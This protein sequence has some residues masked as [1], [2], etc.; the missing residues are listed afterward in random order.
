MCGCCIFFYLF[1]LPLLLSR[2]PATTTAAA[3]Q[4]Y[5]TDSPVT[6]LNFLSFRLCML[7]TPI[8]TLCVSF[9]IPHHPLV[10]LLCY[11]EYSVEEHPRLHQHLH[12]REDVGR[13]EV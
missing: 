10:S 13:E 1:F 9:L 3:V 12:R 2:S 4:S 8:Y 5:T 7:R 11:I 6:Q